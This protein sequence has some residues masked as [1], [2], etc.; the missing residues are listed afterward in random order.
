MRAIP[1]TKETVDVICGEREAS[2]FCSLDPNH[3]GPHECSCGGSWTFND[4]GQFV[5]VSFPSA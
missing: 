2:C 5:V 1:E 4:Q 3:D